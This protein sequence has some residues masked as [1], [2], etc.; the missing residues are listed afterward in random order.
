MSLEIVK[1]YIT[2][3]MEFARDSYVGD[4]EA[5]S[6]EVLLN[7]VGGEERKPIDFSYEVA[8][9]NRRFA[10]RISGGTPEAWP[11]GGWMVAPEE[12]RSKEAAVAGVRSATQ[13]MIE[14]WRAIPV[15]EITKVI[16][17]PTGETSP[18]D[19][20][21]SMCWHNGYHDAQLNYVQELKGDM[22]MHWQD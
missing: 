22:T 17:L 11:E 13:E 14:A 21:F 2:K 10:T 9:V 19:L 8:F 1:N 5:M 12:F 15:D 18:L 20:A 16:P 6:E 7:G 3:Q 4:L